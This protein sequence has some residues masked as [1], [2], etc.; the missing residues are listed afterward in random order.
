MKKIFYYLIYFLLLVSV[1]SCKDDSIQYFV[2][3]HKI[4]FSVDIK[5]MVTKGTP[6]DS[7]NNE[8]F[9]EIGIYAL[10]ASDGYLFENIKVVKSSPYWSLENQY[11]WPQAGS[12]TFYGYFPLASQTNGISISKNSD[13]VPRIRYQVP[14][15]VG[16]QPD[17][18]I[19]QTKTNQYREIVDMTFSHALSCIDRKSVV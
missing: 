6:I 8:L 15:V 4:T 3:S 19:A 14:S 5:N 17:L 16:D 18:M 12:L 1:F 7:V 11:Y 13:S 9:R 10:Q 2:D